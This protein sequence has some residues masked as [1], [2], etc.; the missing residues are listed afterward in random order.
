[1]TM[2]DPGQ[3]P[4]RRRNRST[5]E[6]QILGPNG[7]WQTQGG[8]MGAEYARVEA[9]EQAKYDVDRYASAMS[10]RNEA[11]G[12]EAIADEALGLLQT[13]P[14]G[15]NSEL[16]SDLGRRGLGW[17]PWVPNRDEAIDMERLRQIGSEGVLGTV[18]ELKGPLS[19][20]DV[21]FLREMQINPDA[22]PETNRNVAQAHRW[23]AR[24]QAAY[25]SAMS[26]WRRDLGSPS[27][28]NAQGLSFDDWW[29]DYSAR[30]LPRPGAYVP[31]GNVQPNETPEMLRAQGYEYDPERGS[32]VR[33]RQVGEGGERRLTPEEAAQLPLGTRFVGTDGVV[34]VRQ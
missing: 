7:Q 17:L 25:G 5:G 30:E 11:Y 3:T 2:Q 26:R 29:A 20:R 34:R 8:G 13:A 21:M 10:G 28:R 15:P 33:T 32:Y 4:R 18:G 9:K 6:V 19:D 16:R 27:A 22:T 31:Q 23:A 1:M 12:R 14:T 24:R